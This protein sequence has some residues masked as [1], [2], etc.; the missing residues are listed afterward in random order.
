MSIS[1]ERLVDRRVRE[2]LKDRHAT[3]KEEVQE[4]RVCTVTGEFGSMGD[5]VGTEVARRLD[6]K[7]YDREVVE[8]VAQRAHTEPSLVE[9]VEQREHGYLAE[10]LDDLVGNAEMRDSDYAHR[11]AEVVALVGAMGKA[12]ILGRGANVLLG[13]SRALRV[14]CVARRDIRGVRVSEKLRVNLE[15]ALELL[16]REDQRRVEWTRTIV[17]SEWKDPQNYDLVLNTSNLTIDQAASAVVAV[18]RAG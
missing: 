18:F 5:K 4:G 7:L 9:A 17:S 13:P 11:L 16:D 8:L 14:R 3:K 10:V 15:Q 2:W 12:V 6:F 1:R